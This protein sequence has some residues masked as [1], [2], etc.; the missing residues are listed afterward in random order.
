MKW[1]TTHVHN[2]ENGT[3]DG[4]MSGEAGILEDLGLLLSG[5][6]ST[7]VS[8]VVSIVC[9][10]LYSPLSLLIVLCH[11][12]GLCLRLYCW[13]K[14]TNVRSGLEYANVCCGF[15]HQSFNQWFRTR[16]ELSSLE[17]GYSKRSSWNM[18]LHICVLP[19]RF[20][21]GTFVTCQGHRVFPWQGI[22]RFDWPSWL[23]VY[24]QD[25]NMYS[26]HF[27]QLF[28]PGLSSLCWD[29]VYR[30]SAS[31]FGMNWLNS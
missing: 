23:V 31:L 3:K 26:V 12:A 7:L 10:T 25:R 14:T 11:C 20:I 2:W 24:W 17:F 22:V 15:N 18:I 6:C 21:H 13:L 19:S 9:S 1:F 27:S 5:L 30:T 29:F 8:L 16:M 4:I 28:F